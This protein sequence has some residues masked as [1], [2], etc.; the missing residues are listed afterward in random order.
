MQPTHTASSPINQIAFSVVDLQRT[1]R[2]FREGLGF[3]PSGGSRI[4]MSSPLAAKVQGLPGAASTCWWMVGRNTW[5]QLELFQFRQPIAELMPHD[6]R[7]CDIGYRRIGVWVQDFDATLHQ[8]ALLGT[9]PIGPI[10]NSTGERRTCVRNPDGVFVELMEAD[11]IREVVNGQRTACPVA[12]RSIT[13]STPDLAASLAYFQSLTMGETQ[14]VALHTSEHESLWELP[15]A[16]CCSAVLLCGDVL[17]EL[18]QYSQPQAR[19]WPHGYR[20][21]DQG[22]LN[23]A[24]GTRD[25]QAHRALCQRAAGIGSKAISNP[26]YL[27]GAG[28][29]YVE[30]ALG[31]SVELLY[32]SR[33]SDSRFGFEPQT[34]HQ[35]PRADSQRVQ[36]TVVVNAP[37]EMVWSALNDHARMGAWIG[38][39]N[40]QRVRQG[41]PDPNGRG[42]QR[43]M[44]GL[45]G[46]VVEEI[47]G[48]EDLSKIRYRVVRGGPVI[49]HQGEVCVERLSPQSTQVHW[50]IRFRARIPLLGGLLRW[51]LGRMLCHILERGF[52]PFIETA[53]GLHTTNHRPRQ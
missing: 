3:M 42:A 21:S 1:E 13:V 40:V 30:D 23:I 47:V 35:R 44:Q 14:A 12:I 19:S 26:V 38:F 32:M 41:A 27:P 11:P 46:V 18:V 52:K 48:V 53:A 28:V 17:L 45:P 7:A 8:L 4:L 9:R 39:P 10:L 50:S 2:W 5:L 43:R 29:Q 34:I 16:Q 22:I 31:F 37:I 24:L 36:A 15:G 25:K 33:R 51:I 49:F 20:L 6:A